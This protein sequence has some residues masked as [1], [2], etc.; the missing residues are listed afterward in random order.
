[1]SF[2]NRMLASIGIGGAK[3]DTRLEDS[4][5]QP[6]DE[7]RG[8]VYVRGGGIAQEIEGIYLHL[9]T[10]YIRE[11]DDRKV[12]YT[13]AIAKFRVTGALRLQPNEE[14]EIPFAFTLP[15][16][17]PSTFDRVRVWIKTGLDI[18]NTVDP[19]DEDYIEVLP[20]PHAGMVLEAIESLGFR[21]RKVENEYAPR[22]GRGV[23]FIQEF[24]FVPGG[25]YYGHLDELEATFFPDAGG[26]EVLL[27]VDRRARGFMGFLEEALDADERMHL[28]R[29]TRSELEQGAGYVAARLEEVIRHSAR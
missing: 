24:E 28:V 10:T 21:I 20:H 6:G 7:V 14:L 1:M 11:R 2:F 16:Y 18:A 22:Y 23:P 19:G 5:Y 12:T 8:A 27:E 29:F 9:L 17:T 15:D 4:R 26:V 13:E 3:V 25:P